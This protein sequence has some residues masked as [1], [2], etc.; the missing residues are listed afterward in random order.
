ML[1]SFF[2]VGGSHSG[3]TSLHHLLRAHP[4]VF[5][6]ARKEPNYFAFEGEN[7]V[8]VGP[9][10]RWLRATSVLRRDAYE[11]LFEDAAPHQVVGEV[12]PRYLSTPSSA[13]AIRRLVPGARIVAVLR[14]P[15]DCAYSTFLH[16]RRE[17]WE[18]CRSLRQALEDEPRRVERGWSMGRLR[19]AGF[20]AEN[21]RRYYEQFPDDQIRVYLYD[22]LVDDLRGTM[23]DLFGFVG[24]DPGFEV[25]GA[26]RYN[27]SGT[28]RQPLLR[29]FWRHSY[30]LRR[31]LRPLLPRAWRDAAH[32]R[33]HRDLERPPLPADLYR[34]LLEIY[35][36]DIEEL[37]ELLGRDLTHWLESEPS[38]ARPGRVAS[39][40]APSP[41]R[42]ARRARASAGTAR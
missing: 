29:V 42:A 39:R 35:R 36:S 8:F 24:A 10:S 26:R 21:L 28:I 11:R 30:G 2:I 7:P 23:A 38:A 4:D 16:R 31:A 9:G 40:T 37:Q 6:P 25:D 22:D 13:A 12:S 32:A 34:D 15:V 27:R 1:P 33:I 19:S 18:P 20:H 17:G 14:H 5:V 41:P 3:T